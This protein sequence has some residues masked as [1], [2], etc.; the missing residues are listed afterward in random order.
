MCGLAGLIHY[1]DDAPV[2][3]RALDEMGRI[4]RHRGPDDA[5]TWVSPDRRAGFSHQRLAI[6]DLSP[7][8]HQP[9]LTSDGLFCIAY[10][11]EIYNYPKL[12]EELIR[13]G[14]PFLSTS[15]T[16]VILNGYREWGI[17]VLDRL[18][19]MFA[20]ALYDVERRET[21]LARDPMGIKPL[22]YSD[23]GQRVA[24]ASE[25]QTLKQ[26][27]RDHEPDPE[28]VAS[29]LS[30]GSIP[31]P[32]T[33]HRAIRALPPASWMRIG[34]DRMGE[35][36]V[37]YHLEQDLGEPEPMGADQAAQWIRE[38][39]LDS[40]SHH[41]IADVPVGAFLSGGVD[42]SALLGLM[43][44]IHDGPICTT[45][46]AMEV[47][48]LDEAELAK[49][50]ARLYC[51]DH[52][53]IPMTI[54]L[55]RERIPL[56]LRSL[57]QPSI[58]GIN[59]YLVAEATVAAGLKVA[60]SGVGGD[61]LFGGYETF[62]VIP[63]IEEGHALLSRLPGGTAF[64]RGAA[65]M[66][67]RLPRGP[68]LS[69]VARALA[70]GLGTASAYFAT[71]GLFFPHEVR[72]LLAPAVRD[73]AEATSPV[74]ELETRVRLQDLSP[75]ERISA[76]EMRQ[77]LQCQ[78]LRDADAMAMR[79]SLEVRTPLVDRDLLRALARVPAPLRQAG[80]AK[81]WLRE[82][83]R[84]AVPDDLWARKKQGFTLPFDHWLRAGGIDA[85]LPDHPLLDRAG[86]LGV[87]RDFDKG[88]VSW[89]RLWALIVL[90][91]FLN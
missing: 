86:L 30:W 42:S 47:E 11:G 27:V 76:I 46:L 5:G 66:I 83:P 71:R 69:R 13:L 55:A 36:Q 9:M 73:A 41:M 79:H 8:G 91:E 43:A 65:T 2:D 49:Q 51:S 15:D 82:A 25:V 61:E 24:F 62:K 23:D 16:E 59:T 64:A 54:D 84:P 7:S 6:V 17:E 57:D 40:V 1:R 58:D 90:R 48:D 87:K 89:S 50:A 21:L 85:T 10:N 22:Y 63:R 81:K 68:N 75:D 14:H 35:P 56:A 32:R 78:L 38:A 19:G 45:T 77:Y 52:R 18:R 44:E 26:V 60:V 67:R 37:Y 39:L 88:Q 72:G 4:Q 3:P 53:E 34:P 70:S 12:R 31:A 74:A 29:F 80:P 28:G 33:L 20:F